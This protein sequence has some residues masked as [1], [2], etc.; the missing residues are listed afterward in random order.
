MVRKKACGGAGIQ[1][2]LWWAAAVSPNNRPPLLQ[3]G[4]LGGGAPSQRQPSF[5]LATVIGVREGPEI[6]KKQAFCQNFCQD[7]K[8]EAEG[9][10]GWLS[11]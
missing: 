5:P 9:A 2:A 4:A 6:Q 3:P 7:F 10:L 8:I 1:A 11:W